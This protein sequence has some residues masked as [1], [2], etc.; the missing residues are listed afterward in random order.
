MPKTNINDILKKGTSLK[1]KILDYSDP[2]LKKQLIELRAKCKI[3]E[4]NK[5]VDWAKLANTYITI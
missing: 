4:S 2:K 5:N 1:V 3:I